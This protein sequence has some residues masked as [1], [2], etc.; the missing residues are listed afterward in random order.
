MSDTHDELYERMGLRGA[1]ELVSHSR[2]SNAFLHNVAADL[3]HR[4]TSNWFFLR[5]TSFWIVTAQHNTY[6][7]VTTYFPLVMRHM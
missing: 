7:L 1:N 4:S 5:P 2:H 6:V 3:T